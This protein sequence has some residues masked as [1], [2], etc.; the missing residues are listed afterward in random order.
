M[1]DPLQPAADLK[2]WQEV[3]AYLGISVREAQY[4]E[5]NDGMPVH[6]LSGPKSRVWAYPQELD[7]WKRRAASA[8]SAEPSASIPPESSGQESESGRAEEQG[9]APSAPWVS[10]RLL[11]GG[12][13][14][15]AVVSAAGTGWFLRHRSGDAVRVS[16]AGNSLLAWDETGRLA[17]KYPFAETLHVRDNKFSRPGRD[18]QI[19][20]LRGDGTKQILFAASF[21][22]SGDGPDRDEIYC[23]SSGGRVLWRYKPN[24]AF[25]FGDTRFDGPWVFTDM[26]VIPGKTQATIWLAVAHH[27]WRPSFILSIDPDGSVKVRFVS[28]GHV[29]A[30]GHTVTPAGRYLLAGGVNNEYASAALA[31]LREDAPPSCSPQTRGSRFECLDGP[32]GLPD[33]YFL[34]PPTEI[35]TAAGKP[36]NRVRGIEE[37]GGAC[38]VRTDELLGTEEA[39][40]YYGFSKDLEPHDVA[41]GDGYAA[42]HRRLELEGRLKHTFAECPQMRGPFPVRRWDQ[43]SGWST[44][45]VPLTSGVGPDAYRG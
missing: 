6:R 19:V 28:A 34:F 11:L 37:P 13:A 42:C 36:Y 25:T 7:A 29:Y 44:L 18:L 5:K 39:E 38:V 3:A 10:R 1:T 23:F 43:E 40:A 20:D 45:S 14:G 41:F 16:V 2:T 21:L 15:A 32:K 4:R 24:L 26:I 31:V 17:W 9:A 27:Q 8:N 35:T 22:Q 30:L 33:R 12:L